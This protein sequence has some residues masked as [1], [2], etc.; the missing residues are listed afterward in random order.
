MYFRTYAVE[1]WCLIYVQI[2]PMDFY[3]GASSPTYDSCPFDIVFPSNPLKK[4]TTMA[5]RS[6]P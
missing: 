2:V 3:I 5:P 4:P 6:L 1:W